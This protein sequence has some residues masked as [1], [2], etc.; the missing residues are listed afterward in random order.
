[1]RFL[2]LGMDAQGRPVSGRRLIGRIARCPGER[3]IVTQP[4][5]A[6]RDIVR[7]H[8]DDE[9]RSGRGFAGRFGNGRT[10]AGECSSLVLISVVDS[11]GKTGRQQTRRHPLAEARVRSASDP[12][13]RVVDP[14]HMQVTA[15]V[16]VA[17]LTRIEIGQPA[18]VLVPG[19]EADSGSRDG[20]G[21]QRR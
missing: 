8:A 10:R 4:H 12:V 11:Q 15:S 21:P 5:P 2:L 14:T 17:D 9:L 16:P 19:A 1:V 20:V 13:L 18:R 7:H 6:G 3:A